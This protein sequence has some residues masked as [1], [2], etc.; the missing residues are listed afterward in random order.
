MK[1]NNF[2]VLYF[3]AS[4][5]AVIVQASASD[6]DKFLDNLSGKN[7]PENEKNLIKNQPSDRFVDYAKLQVLNK[8]TGETIVLD[9]SIGE[10]VRF[11]DLE[12]EALKCWKSYPEEKIENKLL[13]K[14][15]EKKGLSKKNLFYGWFFSSSPSVSGLEHPLYDIKLINCY[16]LETEDN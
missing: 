14:I 1:K 8:S 3:L 4:L 9:V 11:E 10:K 6:M 16:N 2:F 13:L 15:N 7:V 5:L 12:I